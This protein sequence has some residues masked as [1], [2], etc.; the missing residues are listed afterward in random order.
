RYSINIGRENLAMAQGYDIDVSYK[1]LCAVCNAVR[2]LKVAK[3]LDVL[4][5]IIE[6][7]TPIRFKRYNR[8][9]GSRHELGGQK[10]AFPAKAAKEVKKVVTNAIANSKSKGMD[11]DSLF[12]VHASANKT[13]IESRRPSKGSRTWGRGMYGLSSATHSDI[14]YAKIEIALANSDDKALTGN[15]KYSIQSQNRVAEA[16]RKQQAPK[17]APKPKKKETA[18]KQE[19]KK[20]K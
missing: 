17:P 18:T 19:A 8:Y 7:R 13:R 2:Y 15:M 12:I 10:G 1:D 5:G 16:K 9:M 20:Q 14:G 4:D 11:A 6:I 3:A